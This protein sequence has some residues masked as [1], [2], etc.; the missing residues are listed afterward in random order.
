MKKID[1]QFFAHTI[2]LTDQLSGKKSSIKIKD[3]EYEIRDGFKTMIEADK[4]LNNQ[5][6]MSQITLITKMFE[7]LFGTTAANE[8]IE[9]DYPISFYKSILEAALNVLKGDDDSGK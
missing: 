4:L 2:D 1:I 8:L 9:A 6:K 3:K 5:S 7:V